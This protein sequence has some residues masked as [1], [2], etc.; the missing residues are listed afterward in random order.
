MYVQ[1]KLIK[2]VGELLISK[3]H[4]ITIQHIN[5]EPFVCKYNFDLTL[6][7]K[8][9]C[10]DHFGFKLFDGKVFVFDNLSNNEIFDEITGKI[11]DN[12]NNVSILTSDREHG[13]IYYDRA[14]KLTM[15]KNSQNVLQW[16]KPQRYDYLNIIYN[17]IFIANIFYNKKNYMA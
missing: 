2:I 15:R 10:F 17:K 16:S 4:L 3:G 5:E 11:L 13:I 9:K 14:E 6:N 12:I 1:N 8:S 7:W